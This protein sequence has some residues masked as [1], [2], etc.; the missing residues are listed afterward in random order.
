MVS[1]HLSIY[2]DSWAKFMHRVGIMVQ[3][4]RH[5][6]IL[7]NLYHNIKLNYGSCELAALCLSGCYT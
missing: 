1:K 3:K 6:T 2:E 5:V 7:V 4:G